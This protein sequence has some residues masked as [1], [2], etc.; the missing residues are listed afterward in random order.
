[1]SPDQIEVG[2]TYKSREDDH[3]E[4]TVLEIKGDD[5]GGRVVRYKEAQKSLLPPME[6]PWLPLTVFARWAK[7]VVDEKELP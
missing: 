1:M 6:Y 3:Y 5:W 2:K 7:S 4:F